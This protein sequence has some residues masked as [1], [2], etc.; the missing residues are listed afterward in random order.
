MRDRWFIP[1][2]EGRSLPYS[3]DRIWPTIPSPYWFIEPCSTPVETTHPVP[4]AK[5]RG[6]PPLAPVFS[7]KNRKQVCS[8]PE[9]ARSCCSFPI[10][11][12]LV[13]NSHASLRKATC[14]KH[15]TIYSCF[16]VKNLTIQGYTLLK[17]PIYIAMPFTWYFS[18]KYLYLL[19]TRLPWGQ[20]LGAYLTFAWLK[21]VLSRIKR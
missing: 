15:R 10:N 13:E 18:L 5:C 4:G 14:F 9:A 8:S 6:Q 2:R 20:Y 17:H 11:N 3:Q 21:R 16:S 19:H 1:L 12:C 7:S